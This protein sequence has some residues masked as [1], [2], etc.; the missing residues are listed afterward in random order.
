[1]N[2]YLFIYYW[3]KNILQGCKSEFHKSKPF[4]ANKKK[5]L[6]QP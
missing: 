3:K 4:S 2:K 1:M 6:G 5:S